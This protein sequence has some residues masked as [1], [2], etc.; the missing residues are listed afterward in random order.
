MTLDEIIID[1]KEDLKKLIQKYEEELNNNDF[2]AIYNSIDMQYLV[3]PPA[4][5]ALL[6]K[7]NINPLNYMDHVPADF[8]YNLDIEKIVIPDNITH[9]GHDA[10]EKCFNLT[11]IIIPYNVV[12]IDN[13]AFLKCS[14]L[15][16]ITIPKKV[17]FIASKAFFRCDRLK[18][19]Y[20]AGSKEDWKNIKIEDDNDELLKANIHYNS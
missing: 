20:Y 10:F 18:D 12:S 15:T 5:T 3:P 16:S 8:A 19:V 14:G 1:N 11:E 17:K 7:N 4:F 6:L 2:S 13:F 9:I